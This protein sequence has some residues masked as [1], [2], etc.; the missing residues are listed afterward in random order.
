MLTDPA[1]P[2][3]LAR[4]DVVAEMVAPLRLKS[5]VA[6]LTLPPVPGPVVLLAT[7]TPLS[8]LTFVALKLTEPAVPVPEVLELSDKAGPSSR[9]LFGLPT[10][11]VPPC[12][13]PR[14]SEVIVPA[15]LT[16]TVFPPNGNPIAISPPRET[17]LVLAEMV[18]PSSVRSLVNTHTAPNE[19]PDPDVSFVTVT[20]EPSEMVGATRD[21]TP[22]EF[23]VLVEL[24]A[25]DGPLSVMLP[26]APIWIFP[27]PPGPVLEEVMVPGPV[28]IRLFPTRGSIS[29]LPPCPAL[30]SGDDVVAAIVPPAKLRVFVWI[31]I[32]P[33]GPSPVVLLDTVT[34][35][36]NEMVG[37]VK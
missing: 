30:S 23:S 26:G 33:L 11:I 12:P 9:I 25:R 34:P 28:M 31:V 13:A 10:S 22:A 14:V 24:T 35:E 19:D 27:D 6:I 21:I 7:V 17:P 36:P 1:A 37:A 4:D 20:P 16:V 29:M 15:P 5:A 3:L 8:K 32:A 18:A 2:A